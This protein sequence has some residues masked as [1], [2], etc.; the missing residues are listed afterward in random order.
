MLTLR[1]KN[2]G[3]INYADSRQTANH[4]V[5]SAIRA[6]AKC[7]EILGAHEAIL[8]PGKITKCPQT[9]RNTKLEFSVLRID[10]C[11]REV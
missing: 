5:Q 10:P 7:V 11:R 3:P 9:T 2:R 4:F 8:G 1:G 6:K